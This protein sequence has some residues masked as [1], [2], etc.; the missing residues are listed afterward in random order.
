[1]EEEAKGPNP[2]FMYLCFSLV[3]LALFIGDAYDQIAILPFLFPLFVI[4]AVIYYY[5][6]L[7]RKS[8]P[9]Y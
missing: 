2:F 8:N 5:K 3:V 1:M 7:T 6:V 9:L 4:S